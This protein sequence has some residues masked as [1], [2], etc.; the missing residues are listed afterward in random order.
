MV[1]DRMGAVLLY[2]D[3]ISHLEIARR[4]LDS[5]SPG[6][7]QLGAVWLPLPHLVMLP[8]VWDNTLYYD[9]FAGTITSM[10]AF[11]AMEV[12]MYRLVADLTGRKFAGI[13]AAADW[14]LT[15]TCSICSRHR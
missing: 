2:K 9:G 15:P 7:A 4:V 1:T 6:L 14:C 5:T 11:V 13:V 10:I 12:L 8:L 3:S